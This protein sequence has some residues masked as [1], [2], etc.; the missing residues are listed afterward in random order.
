MKSSTP[1]LRKSATRSA[2]RQAC[3]SSHFYHTFPL[4]RTTVKAMI[5]MLRAKD[6]NGCFIFN[7][8]GLPDSAESF[9]ARQRQYLD[10]LE[11]IERKER[12]KEGYGKGQ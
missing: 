9:L 7:P 12:V 4:V 2:T 6:E 5:D 8:E 11:L 10:L 1:R 3:A